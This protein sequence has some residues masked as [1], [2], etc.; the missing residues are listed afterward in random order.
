MH[1]AADYI[2]LGLIVLIFGFCLYGLFGAPK[3]K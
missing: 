3:Q 2:T 1:S